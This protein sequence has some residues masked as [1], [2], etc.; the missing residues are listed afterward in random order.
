MGLGAKSVYLGN[1]VSLQPKY[2]DSGEE[3]SGSGFVGAE[4]PHNADVSNNAIYAKAAADGG[5]GTLTTWAYLGRALVVED[6]STESQRADITARGSFTGSMNYIDGGNYASIELI[7]K[8]ETDNEKYDE[9]VRE[10][11]DHIDTGFEGDFTDTMTVNLE[12]QHTYGVILKLTTEI[13]LDA[14]APTE[15]ISNFYNDAAPGIVS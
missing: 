11:V 4:T 12:G 8:D 1:N 6:S 9:T 7:V 2:G 15:C 13:T 14:E 10:W 5:H 3:E